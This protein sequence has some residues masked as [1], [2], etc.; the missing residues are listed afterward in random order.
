MKKFIFNVSFFILV[1]IVMKNLLLYFVP[2]HYGNPWF[3]AKIKYLTTNNIKPDV[4]F[5]GSSRIYRQINP[6]LF[7]SL[8]S[9]SDNKNIISYNLGAPATFIPQNYYLLL[10]FLKS[11]SAS[12]TKTVFVELQNIVPIGN[13][14]THQERSSYW[15]TFSN[16]F[17]ILKS[18]FNRNDLSFTGKKTIYFSYTNA[19]LENLLGIGYFKNSL[20]T[21]DFYSDFYLG[22]K[23]NGFLPLDY[24]LKEKPSEHL[25]ERKKSLDIKELDTRYLQSLESKKTSNFYDKIHTSYINDLINIYKENNIELIFII[26]PRNSSKSLLTLSN[27]INANV[28]DLSTYKQ[29]YLPKYSFDN[30]HVN[31]SGANLFTQILFKE[32]KQLKTLHN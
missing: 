13:N 16:Y 3:S 10:K 18:T 22:P 11:N 20:F 24:E 23:K 25:S 4:V 5:F 12:N 21:K 15:L 29:F 28:I 17:F 1:L 30:G 6:L 8:H 2:Y 27:K 31:T 9:N 26:P 32:Y 7:D 14:L 19:L